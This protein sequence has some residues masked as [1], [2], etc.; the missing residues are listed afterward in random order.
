MNKM[1]LS[2]QKKLV[3]LVE[4]H[5]GYALEI[6][7]LQTLWNDRKLIPMVALFATTNL[8]SSVLEIIKSED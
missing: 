8:P 7:Y 2:K 4:D 6:L 3:Q 1:P 5:P